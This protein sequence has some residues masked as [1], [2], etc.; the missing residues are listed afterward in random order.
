MKKTTLPIRKI[1]VTHVLLAI[2]FIPFWAMAQHQGISG[3]GTKNF[4]YVKNARTQWN[5]TQ[6]N[7][8]PSNDDFSSPKH[9]KPQ[10]QR[11]NNLFKK[12]GNEINPLD[13]TNLYLEF[14]T[15]YDYYYYDSLNFGINTSIFFTVGIMTYYAQDTSDLQ[16][17][18]DFGDGNDTVFNPYHYYYY[19]DTL[20]WD[21]TIFSGF[22][23]HSYANA[24]TFYPTCTVITSLG[25]TAIQALYQPINI[26][27]G[28]TNPA[29]ILSFEAYSYQF[30][31]NDSS[32]YYYYWGDSLYYFGTY[33]NLSFYYPSL[34]SFDEAFTVSIDFGDGTDTSFQ[35]SY[36]DQMY[37]NWWWFWSYQCPPYFYLD[38]TMHE[39]QQA[40][41]Y[42]ISCT[43]T[44]PDG[45]S[46]TASTTT[47]V[48]DHCTTVGGKVFIDNNSNCVP[49]SNETGVPGIWL[50]VPFNDSIYAYD[51]YSYYNYFAVT[52]SFGNYRFS[53]PDICPASDTIKF[54]PYYNFYPIVNL[55]LSCPADGYY[56]FNTGNPQLN[57]DFALGCTS[58]YDLQGFLW[59]WRFRPGFQGFLYPNYGNYRCDSVSGTAKLVIENP[60]FLT[61]DSVFPPASYVNGDTIAWDFSDISIL[62]WWNFS[63]VFI[64]T[65]ISANEGDTFHTTLILEP[66]AGDADPSN[67]IIEQDFIVSNS[68]DPNE[69]EV[70]PQGKTNQGYIDHDQ[71]L[72]Y[73]VHF[74]NTGSDTAYNIY[75]T[76]TLN[77]GLNLNSLKILTSSHYMQYSLY[78]NIVTFNFPNIMLPDSGKD[79][80]GSQGFVSYKITPDNYLPEA[81]S[82]TNTAYIFF[83]YNPAVITN[84]TL[85]TVT[86]ITGLRDYNNS[87]GSNITVYPN[88]N[89]T[90]LWVLLNN[91]LGTAQIILMDVT[92]REILNDVTRATSYKIN[93]SEIAE[94]VYLL[95]VVSDRNSHLIKIVVDR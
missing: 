72:T 16:V 76:D 79:L 84:T 83:D 90:E 13:S 9:L 93:T 8:L 49:D 32:Y 92:G 59:G 66:V 17:I 60:G 77:P 10:R 11:D 34:Q 14:Y 45:S 58:G 31:G 6:S 1:V 82:L 21:S 37:Y 40:G 43:I 86:Y 26:S 94:G 46:D 89:K 25:D 87:R 15:C 2:L 61:I 36:N 85:N 95:K 81:T 5:N 63:E 33:Y 71:V 55:P 35:Y 22:L 30:C 20:S 3:A 52:D 65:D 68:W 64:T 23:L 69:K 24:G 12:S 80:A 19:P 70:F 51:C 7:A 18:I 41:T 54:D 47:T 73:V 42:N 78:E 29:S 4:S 38:Y 28:G 39:Y 88:P 44:F 27:S 74:Q 91:D 62:D 56:V 57:Y 53:F 48:A 50:Y 67:N 75:I